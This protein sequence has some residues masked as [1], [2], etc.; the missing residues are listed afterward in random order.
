VPILPDDYGKID[1]IRDFAKSLDYSLNSAAVASVLV[2]ALATAMWLV[3]MDLQYVIGG[4][5]VYGAQRLVQKRV[6]PTVLQVPESAPR[7]R[8]L[9][10][11][12]TP[13]VPRGPLDE[14]P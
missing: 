3:H 4:L 14:Q 13:K 2:L 6:S 10:D 11:V 8:P 9:R 5:L 7:P 1:R 12:T